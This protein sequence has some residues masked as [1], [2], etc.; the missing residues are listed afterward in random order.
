MSLGDVLFD[1]LAEGLSPESSRA[2]FILGGLAGLA[3]AGACVAAIS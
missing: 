1:S 3:L 2:E